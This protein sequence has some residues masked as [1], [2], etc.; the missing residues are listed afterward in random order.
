MNTVLILCFKIK[1]DKGA[2]QPSLQGGADDEMFRSV[3]LKNVF[4]ADRS[5]LLPKWHRSIVFSC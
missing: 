3:A 1:G 4:K 2:K 5:A